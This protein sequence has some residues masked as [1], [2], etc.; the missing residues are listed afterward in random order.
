MTNYLCK[1]FPTIY[2]LARIH[3]LQ[4]D[5]QT[6]EQTDDNYANS[7]TVTIK[8]TVSKIGTRNNTGV[9]TT[10]VLIISYSLHEK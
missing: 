6:D 7:S 9:C 8:Y 4:T 10:K 3:P 5:R 1:F 2:S